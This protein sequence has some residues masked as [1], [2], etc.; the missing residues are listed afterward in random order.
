[1]AIT[2][3]VGPVAHNKLLGR[4]TRT[5]PW[6]EQAVSTHRLVEDAVR[7][8]RDAD[9]AELAGYSLIEMAEPVLLFPLFFEASRRFLIREG[10]PEPELVAA[11]RRL[12]ERSFAAGAARLELA[13]SWQGYEAVVAAFVTAC[14]DNNGADAIAGY[15]DAL[16]L[17]RLAH[18]LAC[19]RVR[20]YADLCARH[21][22][23][24]RVGE[25][26]DELL[27]DIYPSRDRFDVDRAPWSESI[28]IL[29]ID[30]AETFRGHLS[31]SGRLGDIEISDEPDRIV[32]SFSPCG[33]G[34]QTFLDT[35]D[36]TVDGVLEPLDDPGRPSVTTRPHDWSW[37][38]AGVCLYCVHCCK[39]QERIP[40][41]R[42]GYP[43]R[44]VDPP[45]WPGARGEGRCT[46]TIYKDLS[47]IPADVYERVGETKPAVLRSAAAW[48]RLPD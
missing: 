22:G 3:P 10:V 13:E 48:Q 5:G 1:M 20:L 19:N 46:W 23:E 29:S 30:T 41:H 42:L 11:S 27:C 2:E 45:V 7:S 28:E 33:T 31:G 15:L 25:F 21:L 18:D 6:S 32:F 8:G 16:S 39:L 14:A 9:A 47:Q 40:I 12:D 26:W 34:G 38:K 43:L 36:D 17:W 4:A 44:V 37:G 35:H 24:D